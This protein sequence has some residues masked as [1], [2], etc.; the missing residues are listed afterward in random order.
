MLYGAIGVGSLVSGLL[1]SRVFRPA[2][3][4]VLTPL[5]LAS[6]GVLALGL[7]GTAEFVVAAGLVGLFALSMMTTITVGITYRQL[8]A[9][10]HL[11]SSVNVIGRMVAWGGQPFGAAAGAA[12]TAVASVPT[13]YAAAGVL[14]IATAIAARLLLRH[15]RTRA[16]CSSAE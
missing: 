2:R 3:V 7:A 9:P 13:A 5:A 11:R 14:M 8:V 4:P 1:F 6:S 16:E 12:L 10:D 15:V